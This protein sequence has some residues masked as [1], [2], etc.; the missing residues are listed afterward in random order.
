MSKLFDA[1]YYKTLPNARG[2]Y[3]K[4]GGRFVAETLIAPLDALEEACDSILPTQSFQD[5]LN[6]DLRDYVGRP[7]P[8]YCAERLSAT[9]GARAF[10]LN[11]KTWR[12]LGRT[13]LI[14]PWDRPVW[15]STWGKHA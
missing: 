10:G 9:L 2:Y 13:R 5:V 15:R 4:Y 12:I 14:I 1:R 11:A 3:G 8:L 7:T 6:D